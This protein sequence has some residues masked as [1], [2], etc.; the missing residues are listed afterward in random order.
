MILSSQPH[1]IIASP[2][3]QRLS[4]I[5]EPMTDLFLMRPYPAKVRRI[6]RAGQLVRG[7]L[8]FLWL[9]ANCLITAQAF[10]TGPPPP[11][12]SDTK[13]DDAGLRKLVGKHL[14]LYTDLPASPEIDELPDVFDD[15]VPQW[16][17]YLGIDGVGR[18]Q[19][20]MQGYLMKDRDPF[21]AVGMLPPEREGIREGFSIDYELWLADQPTAYYRRHLLLHEGTHGFMNTHLGSC[22]PGWY[23]EGTAELLATHSWDGKKVTLGIMPKSRDE[24]PM[25][26]RIKLIQDAFSTG[27]QLPLSRLLQTNNRQPLTNETYAWCWAFAKF[28]DSHPRYRDRFRTLPKLVRESDFNDRFRHMYTND[29]P[30]LVQEW[31]LFVGTLDH[32]HDIERSMIDFTPAQPIPPKE[33]RILSIAVDRG[34]QSTG[35]LLEAGNTYRIAA[36]GRYQ[37]GDRPKP[38]P[39]EPNGVT[40]RYY[41]GRPLGRVIGTLYAGDELKDNPEQ[42]EC[43]FLQPFDIGLGTTIQPDQS[44]TLYL[45]INESPAQ[46]AD[47][48][49]QATIEI[50]MVG[51]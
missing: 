1:P 30:E 44:G 25:L 45:K 20:H 16:A 41:A 46:L 3:D 40:I 6:Q 10:D 22:G 26:G 13:V 7:L 51:P 35:W 29:W 23:M 34:W 28:L 50:M 8:L 19:W 37:M 38:W 33:A 15:A 32:N 17:K 18:T 43:P 12:F 47:N 11:T 27:R 48:S 36:T 49:G 31:R 42:G 2:V 24:V 4:R 21:R 14:T 5:T 39:C 9:S